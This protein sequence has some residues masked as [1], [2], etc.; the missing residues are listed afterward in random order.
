MS[1]PEKRPTSLNQKRL[2]EIAFAVAVASLREVERKGLLEPLHEAKRTI[3]KLHVQT[4]I[5]KDELEQFLVALYLFVSTKP[6][7]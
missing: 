2:G 3:E 1:A 6:N 4:G 5:P 7:S